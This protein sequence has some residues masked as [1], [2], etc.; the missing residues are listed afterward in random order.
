MKNEI[1]NLYETTTNADT[2]VRLMIFTKVA[3][4][5]ALCLILAH[6]ESSNEQG[7]W[8]LITTVFLRW[9]SMW[10][11]L[12]FLSIINKFY[13]YSWLL[14]CFVWRVLCRGT[15]LTFGTHRKFKGAWKLTFNYNCIFEVIFNVN[16]IVIFIDYYKI[17]LI[18]VAA[19]LFLRR[20]LC[21]G[22]TLTFGT[23]RKFKRARKH[24]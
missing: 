1:L 4:Q 10:I 14:H 3:K 5:S 20:A 15:M 23:H 24:S 13:W 12:L 6:T 9:F 19:S 16:F 2:C 17:L 18:L 7:K 11:V 8:L 21:G 22:P